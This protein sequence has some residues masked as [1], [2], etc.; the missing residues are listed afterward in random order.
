MARYIDL[1]LKKPVWFIVMLIVI[2]VALGS[3]LKKIEF[4]SSVDAMMPQRDSEY[5]DNQ[6]VKEIYGNNGKFMIMGVAP[7]DLWEVGTLKQINQLIN[8]IEE[9]KDFDKKKEDKRLHTFKSL[10][11]DEPVSLLQL[12]QVYMNDSQ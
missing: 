7:D 1:V 5:L 11:G 10:I 12:R 4:D 2:T 9:Y 8:D 3:G 6:K